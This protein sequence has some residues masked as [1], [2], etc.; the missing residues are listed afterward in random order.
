MR[1]LARLG[2]IGTD[3]HR[4]RHVR[5]PSA[6]PSTPLDTPPRPIDRHRPLTSPHP[7]P[8]ARSQDHGKIS[9]CSSWKPTSLN[10]AIAANIAALP[11]QRIASEPR[12]DARRGGPVHGGGHGGA[13]RVA[14]ALQVPKNITS[15][16]EAAPP[17]NRLAK[18]PPIPEERWRTSATLSRTSARLSSRCGTRL[19][20]SEG[21][22]R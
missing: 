1:K 6:H 20:T 12:G 8:S 13:R 11:R 9:T 2:G 17:K 5:H 21:T 3:T 4:H 15:G 19:W 16:N 18:V 14:G 7:S 22:T 10:I